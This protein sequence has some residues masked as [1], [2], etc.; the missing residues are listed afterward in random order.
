MQ[1]YMQHPEKR[2]PQDMPQE[3]PTPCPHT[4]H[5]QRN[6]IKVAFRMQSHIGWEIFTKGRV[7]REWVDIMERHYKN[8]GLKLTGTEC[9]TKLIMALWDNL[10]RIWMYRNTRF[11]EKD[12]E[13]VAR[14]K[15]ED[16]DRRIHKMWEKQEAVRTN[17]LPFQ[18]RHFAS[19]STVES[20]H[21]ESKRCWVNLEEMY[22]EEAQMPVSSDTYS[23]SAYL[24]ARIYDG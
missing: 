21:Y 1:H 24:S 20:L 18:A 23:L 8:E 15:R 6:R 7:S 11:H 5:S 4:F 16:M 9:V 13:T 12:N 3:P 22:T 10:Q 19:R 17:M 2:D 14:Y